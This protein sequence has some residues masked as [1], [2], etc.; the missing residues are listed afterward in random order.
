MCV[1]VRVVCLCGCGCGC[2]YLCAH[3]SLSEADLTVRAEGMKE[4]ELGL[5]CAV[6]LSYD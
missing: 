5:H 2:G 3:V 1:C 6:G 4:G